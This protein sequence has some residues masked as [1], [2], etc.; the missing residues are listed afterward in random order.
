MTNVKSVNFYDLC[1]IC[2]ATTEQKVDIFSAEG[3]TKNLCAKINECMPLNVR[4]QLQS[5]SLKK[6]SLS[7][8]QF[9]GRRKGSSTKGVVFAMYPKLGQLH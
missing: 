3:K 8:F 7:I 4:Y 2:T 5:N 6:K 1:R 9:L